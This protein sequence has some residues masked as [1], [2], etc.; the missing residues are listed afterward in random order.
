VNT[1]TEPT[2]P[3]ADL[4]QLRVAFLLADAAC[5]KARDLEPSGSDIAKGLAV[6][7][8]EVRAIVKAANDERMRITLAIHR[9]PWW[10]T[11]PNRVVA[12]GEMRKIAAAE[13]D[14][15]RAAQQGQPATV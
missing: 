1:S 12:E 7:S 8:D 6:I 2:D 4:V 11:V 5:A 9:H 15:Q 10:S 14:A 13:Y 3:P